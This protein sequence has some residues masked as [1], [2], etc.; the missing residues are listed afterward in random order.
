[1]NFPRCTT[2]TMLAAGL[3]LLAP[4]TR[5]DEKSAER[6]RKVDQLFAVF[7]KPDSPGCALGIVQ[8]G[9]FVYKRGYGKGS[10]ELGV[11]L[12]PQSV[13]YMGSVSKQFTAASIVLAAEQGFL[14]LDDDVHK[15]IPELPSYGKPITL[16]DMLH[17][18]SGLRDVLSLLFL[19]GRN[20]EDI[21]PTSELI[22]LVSHQKELNYPTGNE[23]LYSNSNYFLMS[24]VI[25][26]ATGKSLSAFAEENIFKPL[27]MTHTRFYED[28]SVVVP[29]RVP[30]YAPAGVDA[31][32]VDW[33][34]NF[35]KVGDGGLMSSVEDL[36]LWDR[37]FYGNKL[38]KGTL[39]KE[40]QT[41][42][43]LNS[44][45]S[46]EYAL[47]LFVST[48]R[49]LPTVEHGGALFGYRTEL[50]RFPDQKFSVIC[51]CNLATATPG[52]LA[53]Q[54][55]DIYLDGQFKSEAQSTAAT[56]AAPVDPK[57]FVGS[58]RDPE[59][60]AVYELSSADNDLILF[61]QHLKATG[62][63][64]FSFSPGPELQFEPV[65]DTGMRMTINFQDSVPQLF[66]RF[67]AAQPSAQDLAQYAG[68]YESSE[69]QT[70]YKFLNKDGKLAVTINWQDPVMLKPTA[71]DE[72]NADSGVS[73]VFRRDTQG[74][75]AALDV[76]AGRVRN[77]HF[78]RLAN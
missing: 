68:T 62:P 11:P 22:D 75:I 76:F 42:G 71:P 48:Y 26:R 55:A 39:L 24:V 17:H 44:G 6:E 52:R 43:M 56:A 29:G 35:D 2:V 60:H 18:T 10:L 27:G 30:A 74:H 47:G 25:K 12:T 13:F 67:Q 38:G 70:K 54:V 32:R 78:I 40:L 36:L 1:M 64:R 41:R 19:S 5:A 46:I 34:T 3:L 49:G 14:S 8:N 28:H 57:P 65:K 50:M 37:N 20:F 15:F 61:G 21:H 23:F 69:L 4:S 16:R 9:E 73:Y 51:L 31:F 72:F 33:S 77:I 7:D 53:N 45:K 63:R 58:Y 66:E 59:S